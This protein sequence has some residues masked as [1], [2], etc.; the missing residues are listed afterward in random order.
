MIL[1]LKHDPFQYISLFSISLVWVI[2][3]VLNL[4]V[5]WYSAGSHLPCYSWNPNAERP[6]E[7][8]DQISVVN[9]MVPSI[10]FEFIQVHSDNEAR[11]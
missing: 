4:E 3:Q 2:R 9:V 11:M 6:S 8:H 7:L 1:I 10:C 5:R